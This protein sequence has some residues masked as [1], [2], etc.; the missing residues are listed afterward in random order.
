MAL[1]SGSGP[2]WLRWT[3]RSIPTANTMTANRPV[4]SH[5]CVIPRYVARY[6]PKLGRLV[7]SRVR[8][9]G[10]ALMSLAAVG[11]TAGCAG[12]CKQSSDIQVTIIA[13]PGVDVS[14]IDRLRIILV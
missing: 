7:Y 14:R 10:L 4:H 8:M 2:C 9:R 1:R 6:A 11:W 3:P 5:T 12:D 13:G